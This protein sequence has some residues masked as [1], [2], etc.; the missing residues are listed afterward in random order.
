MSQQL[1]YNLLEEAWIPVDDLDGRERLVSLRELFAQAN[2]LRM[3]SAGLSQTNFAIVRLAVAIMYRSYYVANLPEGTLRRLWAELWR[4][5]SFADGRISRYLDEWSSRFDLFDDE[6]PFYQVPGLVYEKGGASSVGLLLP[7]VPGKP[8]KFLFSQRAMQCVESLSFAEAACNLLTVQAWDVSGI[9]S[10]V[11]GNTRAKSGRAYPAG[12]SWCGNLGGVMLEGES[13]FQTLM[14]NWPLYR[15]DAAGET[16][17]GVEGDL[18]PWELPPQGPD[19][20]DSEPAGPVQAL[21]WQSRRIRLVPSGDGQRVD[22]VVMCYGDSASLV[23]KQGV[24]MMTAWKESEAQKK[25]LGIS[26][27]P[28]VPERFV[29]NKAIWRGLSSL[30]AFGRQSGQEVRDLRPG[31]IKWLGEMWDSSDVLAR[32]QVVSV[33]GY[34]CVYGVQNSVVDDAVDDAFRM[35]AAMSSPFSQ[36]VYTAIDVVA[37]A[38]KAVGLLVYFVENVEKSTGDRRRYSDF[39]DSAASAVKADVRE[40]AYSRLDGLFRERLSRFS[41]Y[42]DVAHFKRSWLQDTCQ[43]V[44]AV[45]LEYLGTSPLGSFVGNDDMTVGRAL[46]IFRAS[47]RKALDLNGRKGDAGREGSDTEEGE[48]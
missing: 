18:P 12:V 20:R 13:L 33:H 26:Y 38:D 42:D 19:Q 48:E 9:K 22:G 46:V 7:D 10:A 17:L 27:L 40:L 15:P 4:R 24:E 3:M 45:G 2:G 1:T 31:V 32:G 25:R 41:P 36:M 11:V 43:I 35:S 29:S 23:D 37:R 28:L 30:L 8:E 44:E 14:L 39:K 5:G 34:G 21:T 47:L 16:L 6:C